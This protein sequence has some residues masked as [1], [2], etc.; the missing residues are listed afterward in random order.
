[1]PQYLEFFAR[2]IESPFVQDENANG[3]EPMGLVAMSVLAGSTIMPAV[4]VIE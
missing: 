4:D 3:P 1:V 2:V